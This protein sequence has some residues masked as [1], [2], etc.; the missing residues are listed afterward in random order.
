VAV[1][2]SETAPNCPTTLTVE[3]VAA[4][5]RVCPRT[6][7][8]LAKRGEIPAVRLGKLYRFDAAKIAALFD[9]PEA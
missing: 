5:L 1:L 2:A 8:N 4:R 7:Q 9:A 3:E 6:V